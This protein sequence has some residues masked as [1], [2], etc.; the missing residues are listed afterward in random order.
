MCCAGSPLVSF[1][2]SEGSPRGQPHNTSCCHRE[3]FDHT[4]KSPHPQACWSV[5]T[6]IQLQNL[7]VKH[8][9]HRPPI[10]TK[11]A[12]KCPLNNTGLGPI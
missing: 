3:A 4:M 11:A 7:G 8:S 12:T 5:V 9:S 6:P 2:S 10:S 1:H